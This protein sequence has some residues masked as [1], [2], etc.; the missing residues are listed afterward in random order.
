M[1]IWAPIAL[2]LLVS[3]GGCGEGD[4]PVAHPDAAE[5]ARPAQPAAEPVAE[6]TAEPGPVPVVTPTAQPEPVPDPIPPSGGSDDELMP[7]QNWC[8]TPGMAPHAPVE[9]TGGGLVLL[10]NAQGKKMWLSKAAAT[11]EKLKE[12]AK[13]GWREFPRLG[14]I[15]FRPKPR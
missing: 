2:C 7:P 11:P 1:R 14:G 9:R 3:L 15:T 8:G 5:A 4:T 13:D 10:E 12:L 6:R